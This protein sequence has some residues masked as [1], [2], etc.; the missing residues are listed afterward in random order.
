MPRRSEVFKNLT[1][2]NT[3]NDEEQFRNELVQPPSSR[4][5]IPRLHQRIGKKKLLW[6]VAA[7]ALFLLVLTILVKP[8]VGGNMVRVPRASMP[9]AAGS[10]LAGKIE[11]VALPKKVLPE[12]TDLTTTDL[13]DAHAAG[14]LDKGEIVT[15]ARITPLTVPDGWRAIS[16]HSATGAAATPGTHA[17]IVGSSPHSQTPPLVICH[18]AVVQQSLPD[19]TDTVMLAMPQSCAYKLAQLPEEYSVS[20]LLR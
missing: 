7:C 20:L 2:T 13:Q 16:M 1:N 19:N 11:W 6:I 17:E 3:H 10:P 15:R 4:L 18:D 9:I 5:S 14:A 8:T 12:N